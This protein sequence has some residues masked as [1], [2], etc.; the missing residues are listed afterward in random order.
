VPASATQRVLR[1]LFRRWGLPQRL[2][3]DNGAPWGSWSDL[4]TDLSLWLIG[5]GVQMHWNHPNRPQ[6]NGIIE[7]SQG[8]GKRWAEPHAC[9][10]VQQLQQ[11]FDAMDRIQREVYAEKGQLPRLQAHPGLSQ[12]ERPYR[13]SR[14]K[15]T[16]DFQRVLE[17]LADYAVTRR[18]GPH[19]HVSLYN[20]N[21]YVG[22]LHSR[23]TVQIMFDPDTLQWL[24]VA[25]QGQLLNRLAVKEMTEETIRALGVTKKCNRP[26]SQYRK[27]KRRR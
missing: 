25:D 26:R 9:S 16:W 7:R 10:S 17:H 21:Y 12:V 3:V 18:V 6:E 8:T 4:P 11:Q 5:L 27:G 15:A 2:R 19:G 23:R 22:H 14:E 13:R 24:V 1:E 20:R